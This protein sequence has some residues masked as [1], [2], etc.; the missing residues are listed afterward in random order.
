[1][2]G[3]AKER[4]V[5]LYK[6]PKNSPFIPNL[7]KQIYM[8][9]KAERYPETVISQPQGTKP[10]FTDQT[11]IKPPQNQLVN[12]QIYQPQK[13]KEAAPKGPTVF[14]PPVNPSPF[15]PPQY[16]QIPP[17]YLQGYNP[18]T[19]IV[20][21]YNINV[22]GVNGDHNRLSLIYEDI[23][24]TR[25][26]V[27]TFTTIGE[28][29][30]ISNF[31]RSMMFPNG[32]GKNMGLDSSRGNG[33]DSLLE[34][35]KFMDLNPYNT[36]KFS[37]NPY[38]GLPK[39]FL[40]YR[41]CYPIRHDPGE[42]SVGCAKNSVGM[43]VRIY[44]LSQ[45]SY[46]LNRQNFKIF[47]DYEEWREIYFY[48]YI[49]ESILRKKVCP[50]FIILYGYYICENSKID[51]DKV[52]SLS[53]S[54]IEPDINPNPF[55]NCKPQPLVANVI[56]PNLRPN[57]QND[58]DNFNL[59]LNPQICS[60]KALVSLTEAPNYNLFGWASKTY[61]I[62]GHIKKQINTGFYSDKIWFSII[63]QIMAALYVMQINKIYIND[64]FPEDNIYIKDFNV[65]GIATQYWK[66]KI[67][68]IDYYIP[69][70]GYLA[71]IDSN[72][73]NISNNNNMVNANNPQMSHKIY[74]EF[75]NDNVMTI[76]EYYNKTFEMFK[77][78]INSNIFDQNFINYGGCRPSDEVIRLINKINSEATTSNEKN[79]G[80]Y[81]YKFMGQ[82]MN[83]RI[84]TYLKTLEISNIRRDESK[85]FNKG[86]I[87]V[88]ED[89]FST[90]KF[91]LF[92]K[93][94][95]GLATILTK[96]EPT[97]AD[98]IE[99]NNIPISSLYHYSKI[100]NVSQNFRPNEALLNEDD[101]LETYII[102]P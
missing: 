23:L 11:M 36:Y 45:G 98:I 70:Y 34:H 44:N 33:D 17:Q 100:E 88:Y 59:N 22:D 38:K 57:I 79:I 39:D 42:G 2:K 101:L 12:L 69:N 20:K 52:N 68:G 8:E 51:F 47:K 61:Q 21:T 5:P 35:L 4:I 54:K 41:S 37:N 25:S 77:T 24:P 48:E 95:N 62:D 26:L 81:I 87:V 91:V 30:T 64:F 75:F 13:P 46:L 55:D 15:F 72:Y 60:G 71:L 10:A 27:G 83:N 90:Y 53:N 6:E 3:G 99:K 86:K 43:N 32:D 89:A 97:D 49:R 50:N 7:Q 56:P 40:I 16:F 9:K 78:T 31:M 92:I 74:C 84:G 94:E 80:T 66:Y 19:P 58:N 67:D 82:Y 29:L 76:N 96:N 14:M 73:K 18:L 85:N 93:L 65:S 1:L 28:R 63:F 102:Q